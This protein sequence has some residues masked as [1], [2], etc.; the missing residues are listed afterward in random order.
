MAL[1]ATKAAQ[2]AERARGHGRLARW[3]VRRLLRAGERG[4]PHAND[5]VWDLWL[6]EPSGGLWE[7]LARWRRPH[8]GGGPSL[9]ALGEPAAAA[10]VIDAARRVGHP[11]ADAARAAILA[12]QQDLVDD[13]CASVLSTG[14]EEFTRFCLENHLAPADPRQAATFF[15]LTGQVERY[16]SADPDH[17]LLALAYSGASEGERSRIRTCIA[18]EPDLVRVLAGAVRRDRM[19]R[20]TGP[21][22]DYLVDAFAKRRDWPAL[23]ELAKDLPV[24]DAVKAAH[25]FDGWRPQGSGATLF[26]TLARADLRRLAASHS[27]VAEPR[28]VRLRTAGVV[29]DGSFAP[30]GSFAVANEWSVD[31]FAPPFDDAPQHVERPLAIGQPAVLALDHGLVILA[32]M[33]EKGSGFITRGGHE[34]YVTRYR[35]S[36]V[37]VGLTRTAAGF[38]ALTYDRS[39]GL[40]LRLQPEDGR[41]FLIPAPL[42]LNL[43]TQL[44]IP[45]Q[46]CPL[47]WWTLAADPGS[48]RIAIAGDGL[49]VAEITGDR[50]RPLATAP[51]SAGSGPRLAFSGPDRLIGMDHLRRLRVWR[52]AGNE[53]LVVAERQLE[54]VP[55]GNF[56]VDLPAA[57]VVAVIDNA[58]S[59]TRARVRYLD[60]E[61]L[62]DLPTPG[63]L[64]DL[65]PLCLFASPDG[66]TLAVGG[67]GFVDVADAGCA[68]AVIALANWPLAATSPA[69]LHAVTAQLGRT[70]PGSLTL[71]FLRLL[72][73]CLAHRFG[74]D[75]AIGKAGSVR[76]RGGDIALGG[77]V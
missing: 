25:R 3:A 24:L 22:A 70:S 57:G 5:M 65:H 40:R 19:T 1:S 13:V 14:D 38:A 61:T 31:V 30:D 54:K 75:V 35:T 20:L 66:A 36:P 32:G 26:D 63:R 73:A 56:P 47:R 12:G 62:A 67:H 72:H 4:N 23:W 39:G 45:A 27:A 55:D 52:L 77:S 53:V 21:E 16:R 58:G 8:T 48:G 2:L 41:D 28:A 7:A 11:I 10:V 51:F 74:M 49:Y 68:P 34:R 50:L 60:G 46:K 76:A 17:S 9:V 59:P 44:G 6:R 18:G 43:R 15:L 42:F 69:D 71:L 37:A 29:F 33:D 64:A